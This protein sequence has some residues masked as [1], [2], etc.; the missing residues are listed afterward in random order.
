MLHVVLNKFWKQHPHKTT[1]VSPLAYHLSNHANKMNQTSWAL[2]VRKEKLISDVLQETL[3]HG[4]TSIDWPA[5]TYIYQLCAD[6]GCSWEDL[7]RVMTNRY[8]WWEKESKESVQS[9]GFD[10]DICI[11]YVH[12]CISL[13]YQH[14]LPIDL[15]AVYIFQ[16]YITLH[17]CCFSLEIFSNQES[18]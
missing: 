6:I 14:N 8:G 18:T 5:K 10:N 17:W 7:L 13:L 9:E 15:N 11:V 4:H 1:V 3:T 16:F 2:L 12:V